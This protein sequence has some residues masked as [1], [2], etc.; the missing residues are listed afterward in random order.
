MDTVKLARRVIARA[1][2]HIANHGSI[3]ILTPLTRMGRKW[4]RENLPEDALMWGG[5]IVVEPRYVGDILQG[6]EHDGLTVRS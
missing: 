6:A 2:L 3:Y 1:D 4:V 5:G